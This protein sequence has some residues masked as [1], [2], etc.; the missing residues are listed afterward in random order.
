M[1]DLFG[2][3]GGLTEV[4]NPF[5]QAT[6]RVFERNDDDFDRTS[7]YRDVPVEIEVQSLSGS[8]LQHIADLNQT[9]EMRAVYI[10]GRVSPLSEALQLGGDILIFNN[11]EWLVTQL[12]EEWGNGEWRKVIVTLQNASK[13]TFHPQK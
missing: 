7:I 4:I 11:N 5:T 3:A 8:D 10:R 12:I 1:I 13:L 2:I 6:L 9:S